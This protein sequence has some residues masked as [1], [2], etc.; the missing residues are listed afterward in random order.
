MKE[1]DPIAFT[2]ELGKLYELSKKSGN[3]S[4]TMKRMNVHRLKHLVRDKK[5]MPKGGDLVVEGQSKEY[6]TLV[7]ATYKNTKLSTLV[8]PDD[9]NK[10]QTSY[11][12]V[13]RAYMDTL[14][15]KDRSKKNKKQKN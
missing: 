1:V 8:S 11:A 5:T 4:V 6:P 2:V 15:K 3:V 13:I 12:T 14:K 9:F 10:F 7:R